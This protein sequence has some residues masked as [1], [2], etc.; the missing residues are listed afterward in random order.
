[1]FTVTTLAYSAD[2]IFEVPSAVVSSLQVVNGGASSAKEF[3]ILAI[4]TRVVVLLPLH[5]LL[6]VGDPKEEGKLLKSAKTDTLTMKQSEA[7]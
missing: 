1:M 3:E 4:L 2:L 6:P 7:S 5:K